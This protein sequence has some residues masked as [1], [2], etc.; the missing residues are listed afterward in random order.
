MTPEEALAYC[1]T[2][3]EAG[4]KT[5]AECLDELKSALS[6]VRQVSEQIQLVAIAR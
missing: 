5:A 2:E 4:R 1:L 3:I 6:S